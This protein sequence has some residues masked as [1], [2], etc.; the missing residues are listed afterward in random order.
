[1]WTKHST[2]VSQMEISLLIWFNT[3]N[4]VLLIKKKNKL[5]YHWVIWITSLLFPI[6]LFRNIAITVCCHTSLGY[7]DLISQA[8]LNLL[9]DWLG[10]FQEKFKV[11]QELILI[12]SICDLWLILNCTNNPVWW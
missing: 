11:S 5:L 2:T 7:N 12:L 10:E 8:M 1:M 9:W 3:G 4:S 6:C